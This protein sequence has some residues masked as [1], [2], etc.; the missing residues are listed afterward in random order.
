MGKPKTEFW[1][2]SDVLLVQAPAMAA[3]TASKT[4]LSL[5]EGHFS[6]PL[7]SLPCCGTVLLGRE[8]LHELGCLS[9]WNCFGLWSFCHPAIGRSPAPG[10]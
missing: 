2:V 3:P 4:P 7:L 8:G 10:V 1:A 9:G 5:I 6:Q